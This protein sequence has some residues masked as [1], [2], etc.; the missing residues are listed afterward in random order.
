MTTLD[1]GPEE[2]WNYHVKGAPLELLACCSSIEDEHGVRAITASDRQQVEAAIEGYTAAGL[3]VLGF[4]YREAPDAAGEERDLAEERLTFLGLGAL[5]DPP[6][7]EVAAAV[8]VCRRAGIRI[9]MITGDDA[10]TAAAV[11]RDVGIVTGTPVVITGAELDG[12]GQTE[13][14][15]LLHTAEELVVARSNPETKLHIVDALRAQ[16]HTVAMTG[17]GVNDAPALRRADIGI[18][19]GAS[20]HRRRARGGDDGAHR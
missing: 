8:A 19:M 13:R 20:G 15:E 12:M 6:R 2:G 1:G 17:D 16:G 9:V 5:F 18:A 14:D 3:R 10:R 7:P 4:A 11:A